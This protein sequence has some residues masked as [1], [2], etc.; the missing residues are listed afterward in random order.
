MRDNGTNARNTITD[1]NLRSISF[2]LDSIR[3][4]ISDRKL[5]AERYIVFVSNLKAAHFFVHMDYCISIKD[6]G[7]LRVA[8]KVAQN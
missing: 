3:D 6:I 5:E 8:E 2:F 7:L 4:E 1:R